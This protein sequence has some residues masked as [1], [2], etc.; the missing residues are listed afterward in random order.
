[1]F[2]AIIQ[3]RVHFTDS[4]I[5]LLKTLFNLLQKTSTLAG[6]DLIGNHQPPNRES[7]GRLEILWID[8]SCTQIQGVQNYPIFHL[9]GKQTESDGIAICPRS[10]GQLEVK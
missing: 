7:L 6:R 3:P 10:Q 4:F 8:E 9:T 2:K 5:V 1:M